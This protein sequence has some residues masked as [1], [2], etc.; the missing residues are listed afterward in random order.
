MWPHPGAGFVKALF[1]KSTLG[2]L[3][4]QKV[5]VKVLFWKSTFYEKVKYLCIKGG[6]KKVQKVP[7]KKYFCGKVLL[8][9]PLYKMGVVRVRS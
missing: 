6:V 9:L 5:K 2:P 8:L 3:Y 1:L 4:I 7:Q